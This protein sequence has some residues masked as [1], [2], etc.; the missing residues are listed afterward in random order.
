MNKIY[1]FRKDLRLEDNTAL[2]AFANSIADEDSI[3]FIYIKNRETFSYYGM[4]RLNFLSVCV[5]ELSSELRHLG[6]NLQ[7]LEGKSDEIFLKIT[8]ELGAVELYFNKQVEP[9]CIDRDN[10]VSDIVTNSGGVINAYDDTTLLPPATVRNLDGGQY[11]V[12]TPFR[13]QFMKQISEHDFTVRRVKLKIGIR[14]NELS[15]DAHKINVDGESGLLKGGRKEGLRLLKNFYSQGLSNYKSRRDFPAIS[16]TSFLSAHFHFG[17]VS[18]REAYRA[19]LKKLSE[20]TS[21]T[22]LTEVRTWVNEL[23]WR[24]FYY[25]IT[26]SNPQLT[27]S[28]FRTEF[29]KVQWNWNVDHFNL[30]CEGKTGFPIVDAGMRQLKIDGWMH[31]R[32]RMITAM[33]LTKDLL[34]DW[35]FGEKFFAENLIDLDFSSN[36]GGW[37][38][39]ASTGVDAQPYFRIFNPYL[40][41]KKFDPDGEYIKKFIPE[42]KSV[43]SEYIHEPGTMSEEIQKLCRVT[44]GVDYPLPIVDH[45]KAKEEAIKRFSIASGKILSEN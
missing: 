7:I 16:G 14:E 42:L 4:K 43:P 26:Y 11:K 17:T 30:W 10:K 28:S 24:E 27:Y 33:F 22:E 35:R 19:A 37:Q 38:W 15:L 45:F 2:A 20:C 39:S 9:Y 32:V 6:F 18:I 23:L 3:S 29:D 44:I 40:Q 41:S 5:E 21:E 31:N 34:I 8:L 25:H 1:W 12:Y 36:N 13:N